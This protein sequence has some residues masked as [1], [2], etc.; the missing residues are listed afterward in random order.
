[1]EKRAGPKKITAIFA[2]LFILAAVV[3]ASI[4]MLALHTRQIPPL[5]QAPQWETAVR[6]AKTKY[7]AQLSY[8]EQAHT[9]CGHE[10]IYVNNT[11]AKDWGTLCL[12]DWP[13]ADVF[14]SSPCG[15][16]TELTNC[17]IRT[18]AGSYT[19]EPVRSDGVPSAISV[20]LA[21]PL[22]AGES[23]QI[24]MDMVIHIPQK[25]DRFGYTETACNLGSFLP[26]LAL[27]RNGE[28]VIHPYFEGGESVASECADYSVT[29]TAPKNLTVICTGE[30]TTEHG[31]TVANASH[32]RDFCMVIGKGWH[33]VERQHGNVRVRSYYKRNSIM[34]YEALSAAV[35]ALSAFGSSI[36][37]YPYSTLDIV[38]TGIWPG[39]IEFPQIILINHAIYAFSSDFFHGYTHDFFRLLVA[40]EVAHQWFYGV[41]GNDQYDDP[42]ID[43]G[44]ATY[45][46]HVYADFVGTHHPI[47]Y[48]E[49]TFRLDSSV[50]ELNKGEYASYIYTAGGAFLAELRE[51]WGDGAFFSLLRDLYTHHG[52]EVIQ[53]DDLLMKIREHSPE[54]STEETQD[55]ISRYFHRRGSMVPGRQAG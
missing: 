31:V 17:T 11:S 14:V 44:F 53:T 38:E 25:Y 55:L 49:P 9:I 2:F 48:V 21:S 32:V 34:G 15:G 46:E 47:G 19:V 5:L 3:F 51:A 12:N 20:P 13:S 29:L 52:F 41:V 36:G 45:L 26:Q 18:D 42:W 22:P 33:K 54:K 10:T 50:Q 23:L 28:W 30:S 7:E 6:N 37:A 8:D 35:D 24:D 16:L 43:E 1:M 27:W 39:G 40:H 4:H